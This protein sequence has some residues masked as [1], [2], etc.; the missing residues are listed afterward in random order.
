MSGMNITQL[1]WGSIECSDCAY[2]HNEAHLMAAGI[3]AL[4]VECKQCKMRG[5]TRSEISSAIEAWEFMNDAII[6]SSANVPSS[7]ASE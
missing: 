1:E 7:P 5:P 2:C 6:S 3:N 4:F